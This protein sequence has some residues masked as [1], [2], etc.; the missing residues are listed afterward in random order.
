MKKKKAAEAAPGEI[1]QIAQP[2]K[3]SGI[4]FLFVTL[5]AVILLLMGG[6]VPFY[7]NAQKAGE[8]IG[9]KAGKMAGIA[10]GSFEGISSGLKEG[11]KDGK[12]QGLSAEDTKAV[13]ANEMTSIGKLD[14]LVAESQFVDEFSEGNDYKALFVYK[15]QVI[16]SVNLEE[17]EISVNGDDLKIII[18]KPE[19]EFTIDED[20]SEK[21]V[22]W[23]KHFWSGNAEAGYIGYMNSMEQIK[24]KATSEMSNYDV[25][26]EQAENSARKQLDI[27]TKS[28]TLTNPVTGN[29]YGIDV[30]FEGEE[31]ED[32]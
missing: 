22:D 19:C 14:V 3:K 31:Y 17:A 23:Q 6:V 30:V 2:V 10:T 8:D 26:M 24:K 20:E 7:L 18:P 25:L 11:Y 21:L 9:T 4:V 1:M 28:I 15:A 13:I 5:I 29:K 16:F 27:L 12:T 32:E